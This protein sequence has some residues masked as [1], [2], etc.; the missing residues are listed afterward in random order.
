MPLG[1]IQLGAPG[2]DLKRLRAHVKWGV[3]H[4]VFWI[5]LGDYTDILSPSNRRRLKAAD[6]YDNA[7]V[8]LDKY[9]REHMKELEGILEP[10]RG[11]WL[12]LH[13]GH[14]LWE[15]S[16]GGTSDTELCK[17]LD[18]PFLG[19]AAVTRLSFRDEANGHKVD[20]LIWSHHGEGG[21][22]DP[23]GRLLKVAPGFPQVDLFLQGHNTQID[24]RPKD[25]IWFFGGPGRL[26]MRN[27]TQMFVATGGFMQGYNQG[28]E[29]NGRK[30]G[31]YV[32]RGMMRPTALGGPLITITPRHKEDFNELDIK[33]SV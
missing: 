25:N 19:T 2:V 9:H 31:S 10:T 5:G 15:Y 26:R 6:L 29:F 16:D 7:G 27:K 21:G 30:M 23:L 13:E 1:D 12:G 22:Q 32:E 8:F 24:A 14:H 4:G 18:A 17:F 11:M 3:E 28:S 33:C 20:C